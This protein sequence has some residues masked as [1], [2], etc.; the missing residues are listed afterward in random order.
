[1]LWNERLT[2]IWDISVWYF[3]EVR[4]FSRRC[5]PGAPGTHL[6]G[7]GTEAAIATASAFE[8][9][10]TAV[11]SITAGALN[12]TVELFGEAL[13]DGVDEA[14]GTITQHDS[15]IFF[16]RD[17]MKTHGG[18]FV[19]QLRHGQAAKDPNLLPP[20]VERF[21]G[22]NQQPKLI[23]QAEARFGSGC[24]FATIRWRQG[25]SSNGRTGLKSSLAHTRTSAA[26]R[27]SI[28]KPP[29]GTKFQTGRCLCS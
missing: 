20:Q 23:R 7:V 6:A 18:K 28:L 22:R 15:A 26:L 10:A 27:R 16:H 4:P 14:S 5:S 3:R 1:V 9:P 24:A 25:E 8:E 2:E 17:Q 13:A 12:D 11:G 29:W 21:G 19:G